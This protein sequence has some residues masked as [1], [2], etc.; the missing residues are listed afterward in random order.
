MRTA[1]AFGESRRGEQ[2]TVGEDAHF[3]AEAKPRPA[4]VAVIEDDERLRQ[5]LVFQLSTA[6]FQVVPYNSAEEFLEGSDAGSFDC[7]V[8]DNFLPRMNGLQLQAQL[9]RKIPF[10]SIVFI[11]GNSELSIGM[12]AMRNGA[13][14]FLEKPLDNEA[15]LSSITRGVELTRKRRADRAHRVEL[16]IRLGALTP[17]ERDVFALITNGLLNKQVGAELGT[18]ERTVKAHRERV[19]LKM[20][21]DSFAG[22]VRMSATLDLQFTRNGSGSTG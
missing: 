14:D 21:A 4:R 3:T 15:L 10:A 5:A 16:E 19:M 11:S 8:V 6:D 1:N 2:K 13:V 9:S 17:R 7:V 22:L 20:K 18:T 12:R